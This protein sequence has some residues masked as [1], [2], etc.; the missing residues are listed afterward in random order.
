MP[1]DPTLIDSFIGVASIFGLALTI[2]TKPTFL[3]NTM[4][5]HMNRTEII[6]HIIL[7]THLIVSPFAI[8]I[9]AWSLHCKN[10]EIS[11]LK[12]DKV[13]ADLDRMIDEAFRDD[14]HSHNNGLP[15]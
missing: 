14:S 9:M 8:G 15:K 11:T 1:S 13:F 10:D 5:P 3:D 7:W 4:K 12:T 2:T 6:I